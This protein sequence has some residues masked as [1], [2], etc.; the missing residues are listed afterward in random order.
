MGLLPDTLPGYRPLADVSM[1]E[2]IWGTSLAREPG[3]SY[4]EMLAGSLKALYVMGANPAAGASATQLAALEA[5]D[6]LVVQDLFLTETAR[7]ASVVL[8]AVA[9]V[10]KDGTFTSTERRVQVV[11][12]AMQPLPGARA[13]WEIL[14]GVARALGLPWNYT[15]PGDILREIARAVPIYAGASRPALGE[16]GGRWPLNARRTTGASVAGRPEVKETPF[17]TWQ[18]LERG[19]APGV[20]VGEG[21][22]ELAARHGQG[23]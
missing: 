4:D 10:E 12:R 15:S 3:R 2:G 16:S 18:M 20:P 17:L 7:F 13:D 23:E 6:F 5:L 21:H 19:V 9:Y 11:R 1:L 8:P 14:R 22:H